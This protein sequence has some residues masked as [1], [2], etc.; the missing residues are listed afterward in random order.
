[1]LKKKRIDLMKTS[2]LAN[3]FAALTQDQK[4]EIDRNPATLVMNLFRALP[5][6]ADLAARLDDAAATDRSVLT[7]LAT[8]SSQ[9]T[10]LAAIENPTGWDALTAIARNPFASSAAIADLVL[11]SYGAQT[12]SSPV[13]Y[14][15]LQNRNLPAF[16][17]DWATGS[18][19][20]SAVVEAAAA[21]PNLSLA[22]QQRLASFPVLAVR[23]ALAMNPA[24]DARIRESIVVGLSKRFPGLRDLISSHHA[25]I[26]ATAPVLVEE[27]LEVMIPRATEILAAVPDEHLAAA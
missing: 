22:A 11:L 9:E 10:I 4:N 6:L 18:G 15:A 24:T 27:S 7:A 5:E 13:R 1:M 21:N 20:S 19:V 3:A 12:Y 17:L 14:Y 16:L 2:I 26:A 8:T 25:R 23:E